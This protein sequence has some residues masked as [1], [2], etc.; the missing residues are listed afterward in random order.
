MNKAQNSK[1]ANLLEALLQQKFLLFDGA[2]GTQ[3]YAEG[4]LLNRSFEEQNIC[5]PDLVCSVYRSYIEAGADVLTTNTFSANRFRL[6]SFGLENEVAQINRVGLALL[7]KELRQAYPKEYG[8]EHQ[9]L[10]AASVGPCLMP[11]QVW[12]DG[13]GPQA[14]FAEQLEALCSVSQED[15]PDII[16]AET[17]SHAQELEALLRA[18]NE[19]SVAP[20]L[21][22]GL[23]IG[24]QGLSASGFALD[25]LC[26]ALWSL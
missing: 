14:A 10:V 7:R 16:L 22:L 6:A 11:N 9:H 4:V 20:A 15:Q 17:F 12:L 21:V 19:L 23:T 26:A 2:I 25:G 24:E 1:P 18:Y 13:E 8:A 3:L 5:N